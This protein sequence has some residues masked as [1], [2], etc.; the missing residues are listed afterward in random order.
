MNQV[1]ILKILHEYTPW[2]QLHKKRR[3]DVKNMEQIN[4]S[5]DCPVTIEEKNTGLHCPPNSHFEE[6]QFSSEGYFQYAPEQSYLVIQHDRYTPAVLHQHNFF[7]LQICVEGEFTQQINTKRIQ[8]HSGDICLIPPY[9][10][11]AVDIQNY[12]VLLNFLIPEKHLKNIFLTQ[13]RGNNVLSQV[14]MGNVYYNNVNDYVIFHTYSDPEILDIVYRICME[15]LEKKEYYIYMMNTELLLLLGTLVRKYEKTCE[16]PHIHRKE[17]GINYGILQFIEENYQ[18]ISLQTLAEKFHY[19]PQRMSAL[20]KELTGTGF[21]NY[22]LE[23]RMT[24]ADDFLLHTNL[25]IKDISTSCGYINQEHF[26][27]TFR[28]YYGVTPNEYRNQHSPASKPPV[29]KS[30]KR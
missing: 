26:I 25:K 13:L 23:K 3:A 9:V 7:E 10:N 30:F 11:H 14:F 19:T 15:T 29:Y 18:H 17:D 27:R 24:A 4:Q 8:I 12:S 22:I 6:N 16:L 1:E 28:K 21:S 20:I 5:L 2:E